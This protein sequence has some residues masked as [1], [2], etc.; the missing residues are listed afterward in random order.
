MLRF[1]KFTIGYA[2]ISDFGSPDEEEF[3]HYLKKYSPYHN[4][5]KPKEGEVITIKYNIGGVFPLPQAVLA[6]PQ[7]GQA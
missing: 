6:L 2:W 1:H 4:V 7:C 3:F 5:A